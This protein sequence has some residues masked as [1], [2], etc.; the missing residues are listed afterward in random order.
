MGQI[1]D[2]GRRAKRTSPILGREDRGA[3]SP[4]EPGI[5]VPV[6]HDEDASGEPCRGQYIPRMETRLLSPRGSRR[7]KALLTTEEDRPH[8]A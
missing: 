7:W 3:N 5:E 1:L 2:L 8:A 4:G 6:A